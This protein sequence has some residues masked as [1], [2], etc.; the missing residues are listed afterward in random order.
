[1]FSY[2]YFIIFGLKVNNNDAVNVKVND[3]LQTNVSGMFLLRKS[4]E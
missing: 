4:P 2:I 1:M 3:L